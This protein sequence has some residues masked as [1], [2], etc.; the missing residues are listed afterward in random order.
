MVV[1]ESGTL[2]PHDVGTLYAGN[3]CDAFS[4]SSQLCEFDIDTA[5]NVALRTNRRVQCISSGFR[6]RQMRLGAPIGQRRAHHLNTLRSCVDGVHS[7]AVRGTR[8][9]APLDDPVL[10]HRNGGDRPSRNRLARRAVALPRVGGGDVYHAPTRRRVGV[11]GHGEQMRAG[12]Y[13]ATCVHDC[14]RIVVVGPLVSAP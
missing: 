4:R 8:K 10:S 11:V 5:P 1:Q 2:D 7:Q 14:R 13:T 3:G 9:I 6:L 12:V